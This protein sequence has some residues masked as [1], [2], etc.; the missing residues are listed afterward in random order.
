MAIPIEPITAPVIHN[1]SHCI[2]N[3]VII[4]INPNKIKEDINITL[5]DVLE[6]IIK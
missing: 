6:S 5:N 3:P 2:S 4:R 1:G